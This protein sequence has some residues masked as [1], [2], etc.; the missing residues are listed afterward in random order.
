MCPTPAKM[1][2]DRPIFIFLPRTHSITMIRFILVFL[3]I[4]FLALRSQ[5]PADIRFVT[6]IEANFKAYSKVIHTHTYCRF[7]CAVCQSFVRSRERLRE[8]DKEREGERAYAQKVMCFIMIRKMPSGYYSNILWSKICR[9]LLT[10]IKRT[11]ETILIFKFGSTS[12]HTSVRSS[13]CISL[14]TSD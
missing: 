6:L 5:L 14:N 3:L 2:I 10:L 8:K 11:M 9:A 4:S 7:V 13:F 12:P 1:K